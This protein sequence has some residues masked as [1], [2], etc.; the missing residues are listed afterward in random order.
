METNPPGA[1]LP[2]EE[3]LTA[4]EYKRRYGRTLMVLKKLR[5]ELPAEDELCRISA[6]D[7]ASPGLW[8][9]ARFLNGTT[10]SFRPELIEPHAVQDANR[11]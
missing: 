8:I 4:T 10:R 11:I 6:V 1:S 9:T 7:T 3:I 2:P 5:A